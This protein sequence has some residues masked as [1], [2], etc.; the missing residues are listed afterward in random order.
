MVGGQRHTQTALTR[1]WPLPFLQEAGWV[2]GPVWRV[3]KI[4]PPLRF[5]PRTVQPVASR[6]KDCGIPALHQATLINHTDF[7][8]K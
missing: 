7:S 5:D 6:Y 1:E 4:S 8:C 2:P 3:R